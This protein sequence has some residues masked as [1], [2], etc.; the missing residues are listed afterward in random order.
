VWNSTHPNPKTEPE[1][2]RIRI[3][4]NNTIMK[5]NYPAYTK[6]TL[7]ITDTPGLGRSTIKID[8]HGQDNVTLLQ[9][10]L[11]QLGPKR[12]ISRDLLIA[13]ALDNYASYV[14]WQVD[15]GKQAADKGDAKTAAR[16]HKNLQ[17]EIDRIIRLSGKHRSEI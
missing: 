11:Q 15:S 13:A 10:L 14:R 16:F 3:E 4:R 17:R 8:D 7:N 1:V 5:Q 9:H 6:K 2:L 12:Q